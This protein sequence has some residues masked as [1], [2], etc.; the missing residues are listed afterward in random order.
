MKKISELS[1]E[2]VITY[3]H[4]FYEDNNLTDKFTE[5]RKSIESQYY[6]CPYLK[7]YIEQGFCYD[8]QMMAEKFVK[9]SVLAFNTSEFDKKKLQ[10]CCFKCQ[11]G[12]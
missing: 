1:D 10:E 3:C 8:M 4:I 7:E 5:Y 12:L 11:Y 9:S 6:Y 2:D